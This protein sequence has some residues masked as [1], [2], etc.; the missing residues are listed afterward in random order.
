MI[1]DNARAEDDTM[2]LLLLIII[3]LLLVGG[4]PTWPYS[5]RWGYGPSGALG[6]VLIILLIL[7]LLDYVPRGF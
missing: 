3:V 7:V 2:G 6:T 4:L 5:R 1:F